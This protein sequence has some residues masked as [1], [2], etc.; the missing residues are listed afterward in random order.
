MNTALGAVGRSAGGYGPRPHRLYLAI[1]SYVHRRW[2]V[3]AQ[4]VLQLLLLEITIGV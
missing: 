3:M 1:L 4:I 2:I